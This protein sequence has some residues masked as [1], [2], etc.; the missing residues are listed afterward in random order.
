MFENLTDRLQDV[1]QKVRGQDK[2]TAENVDAALVEVRKALIEADVSLKVIKLFLDRIRRAAIGEKVVQGI[3]P[4]QKFIQ[5][6]NDELIQLLGQESQNLELGSQKPAIIMLLGLQG[7][8]KTTTAA[9][10]AL[11][12]QKDQKKV[13]L[14]A[15]DLQR[16]AAIDQLEILGRQVQVP[17][18]ADKNTKDV[19]KVAEAAHQKAQAEGF[20]VIIFDTAGRLQIDN[21]LMAELLLLERK[22]KP[23]E[24]LL[25][26]DSLIGQ[27]ASNIAETFNTQIGLSGAI[28]SKMDGDSRGGAALSIAEGTGVKIKFLGLGEQIEPL[29][30]FEP[31]RIASRILGFGDIVSLVQIAEEKFDKQET[32]KLEKQLGKGI[33]TFEIFLKMQKLMSKLGSLSQIMNLM[34][35]NS[36]LSANKNERE[37]LIA[38]GELKLKS[39]E[40]AIESMTLAERQKPELIN[41]SRIRR[42]A[43]G[44]GLPEKQVNNL[45]KEFEQMRSLVKMLGP[46]MAGGPGNMTPSNLAHVMGRAEKDKKKAKKKNKD[47][48]FSGGSFMRF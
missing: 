5:I 6:V 1:L 48:P 44:S 12:L 41:Q 39:Y 14:A 8:G 3:T 45:I 24:K 26:V 21:E 30:N 16:P 15:L 40:Y 25:V 28:L 33:L 11:N 19:L 2:L 46:M 31:A 17:V 4:S 18:Y 29:E 47:G 37:G 27:A 7:A 32:A 23:T 9:K 22:Y 38:E 20:E 43:K 35:L 10:L 42:I 13:L 36:M 34:G